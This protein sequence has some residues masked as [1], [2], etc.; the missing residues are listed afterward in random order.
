MRHVRVLSA[1]LA[2]VLA[3]GSFVH[4]QDPIENERKWLTVLERH[5]RKIKELEGEIGHLKSAVRYSSQT[6]SAPNDRY[7][8][9]EEEINQLRVELRQISVRLAGAP[10]EALS[11]SGYT[12]RAISKTDP[13]PDYFASKTEPTVYSTPSYSIG[14]Y[15]P[16]IALLPYPPMAPLTSSPPTGSAARTGYSAGSYATPPPYKRVVGTVDHY[17]HLVSHQDITRIAD[18]YYYVRRTY[19]SGAQS[20][21]RLANGTLVMCNGFRMYVVQ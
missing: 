3:K 21:H 17:P 11:T 13:I 15:E 2:I 6:A 14:R 9:L 16:S 18:D 10:S 8:K 5:T 7:G 19:L 1:I 20:V 12:L 4:A